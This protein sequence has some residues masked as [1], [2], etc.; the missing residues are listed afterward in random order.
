MRKV[1]NMSDSTT[2]LGVTPVF[3]I[4]DTVR[5][6]QSKGYGWIERGTEFV[7]IDFHPRTALC[8]GRSRVVS[9]VSSLKR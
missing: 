9:A 2:T 1:K 3:E 4:G 8:V 7:L 5:F 6:V